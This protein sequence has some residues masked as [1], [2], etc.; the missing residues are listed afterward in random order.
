MSSGPAV[1]AVTPAYE[2]APV[3]ETQILAAFTPEPELPAEAEITHRR[4]PDESP[5]ATGLAGEI[6]REESVTPSPAEDL[7]ATARP[8]AV[9]KLD[10]QTDLTQIETNPAKQRER[11]REMADE[12]PLLRPKRV[13]Q[14]LAPVDEGPLVQVETH[15]A[16]PAGAMPADLAG[17]GSLPGPNPPASHPA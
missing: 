5:A 2:A 10:W 11:A 6:V 3:P 4:R 9:L 16:G 14:P 1:D 7:A 15:R 12:A 8:E 17:A 13:R